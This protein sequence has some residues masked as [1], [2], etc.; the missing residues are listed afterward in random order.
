[1][2]F[3]WRANYN[4]NNVQLVVGNPGDFQ[5]RRVGERGGS[6]VCATQTGP[7]NFAAWRSHFGVTYGSG[8][9]FDN[10]AGVPEP[11]TIVFAAFAICGLAFRR[12]ASG[13][14]GLQCRLDYAASFFR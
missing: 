3:N 11:G 14:F 10:G 1:M 4:A 7:L 6:R 5:L 13:A 8:A 2:G 12:C 9:G